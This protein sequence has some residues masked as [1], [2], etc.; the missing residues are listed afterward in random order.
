[1]GASGTS[2]VSVCVGVAKMAWLGLGLWSGPPRGMHQ[3]EGGCPSWA[4]HPVW[5]VLP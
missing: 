2:E 1:M 3:A 4:L 5:W